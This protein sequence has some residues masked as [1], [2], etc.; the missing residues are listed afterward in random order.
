M[1]RILVTQRVDIISGRGERRDAL[2]Q[3]LPR[4]LNAC[5]FLSVPVPN[6]PDQATNLFDS[7]NPGGIVLSG[8]NDLAALG[9]DAPERDATET[10]LV[11]LAASRHIP[12]VGICRGLQFLVQ[13]SGGALRRTD[14]HVGRHRIR[15][16]Q[17]RDVNSYHRWAVTR[18]GSGWDILA[19][20]DDESIE[21]AGSPE[22]SQ[23]GIMWHPEREETLS[24]EDVSLF[25]DLLGS[26][27]H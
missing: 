17:S 19:T 8:G 16:R 15:G 21:F 10:R 24:S 14:G 2:D 25:R 27:S 20:A 3:R 11:H 22:A 13:Q 26:H 4:F 7:L 9:G 6:D 1:K 18:C 23:W 12:V 5:G